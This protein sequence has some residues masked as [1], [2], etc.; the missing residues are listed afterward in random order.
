[1]HARLVEFSGADPGKREAAQ[2]RMRETVIPMLQSY[3]G[4]IGFIGMHDAEHR[5]ARAVL[6]W[7]SKE[8]AETAEETLAERRKQLASGVGLTIDSTDLY[9]VLAANLEKIPAKI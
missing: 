8:A 2:E 6:L 5:K 4:F 3:D 9:E 7:E 1:M